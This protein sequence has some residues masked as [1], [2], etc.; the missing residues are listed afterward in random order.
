MNV[1]EEKKNK[2]HKLAEVVPL[3]QPYVIMID[4]VGAICNFKCNFCPCNNSTYKKELRQHIMSLDMF[5]KV[6]EDISKFPN[7]IKAID[8]YGF[9]EPL[10]NRNLPIMI[11]KLKEK[12][13]CEKIRITTNASLLTH[14]LSEKLVESGLD[15]MKI[16]LEGLRKEDYLNL[17][18]YNIDFDK[19]IE[20]IKYLYSISREKMEIGIKIVST[21]LKNE[22][23]KI[24]FLNKFTP[25]SDYTFIEDI[26][27][28]WAEFHEIKD[29]KRIQNKNHICSYPFTHMIIHSNGDIGICCFDWKHGTSYMNV[30]NVSVVDAWN[31]KELKEIRLKHLR[32]QRKKIN[33][34]NNCTKV[35]FDNI[36]DDVQEIINKIL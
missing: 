8:L 22:E 4:P 32:K 23:D 18:E 13:I 36:D 28:I 33:Y 25:I 5:E 24:L 30:N 1:R 31:S 10:L 19:F 3:E 26:Q 16:S 21:S 7:K 9:G 15:Y 12:N 17:C 35:G 6:I 11:K 20:N 2:R 29:V 27:D 14:E 34:C